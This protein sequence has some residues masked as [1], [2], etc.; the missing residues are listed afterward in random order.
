MN[1]EPVMSAVNTASYVIHHNSTGK[2]KDVSINK[3]SS[4][5][6]TGI[7]LMRNYLFNPSLG[8]TVIDFIVLPAR[9]RLSIA[10]SGEYEG[11]GFLGLKRL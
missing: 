4:G 9:A 2:S 3:H 1:G 11:E 5:N 8:L 6:V 10:Y 7:F